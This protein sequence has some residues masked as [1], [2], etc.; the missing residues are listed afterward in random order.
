MRFWWRAIHGNL[1]LEELRKQEAEIFGDTSNKSSFRMKIINKNLD[2]NSF[3]PLPHK[4]SKFQI[5]GF[6]PDQTFEIEF[7]GKKLKSVKNAFI[8]ST[9][10]GGFGQRSRRGFGSIKVIEIDN[11]KLDFKYSKKEIEELIKN[12]NS[13]FSFDDSKF[14]SKREFP[15]IKSIEIGKSY[16]N[17]DDILKNIG[18]AT[19]K[20][21]CFGSANPRHASPIVVSVLKEKNNSYYPILTTLNGRGCWNNLQN[22]KGEI[23]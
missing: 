18:I 6:K 15:Y 2:A 11:D 19:H 1:S 8:L 22:F 4:S 16:C 17:Y 20:Y 7:L 5:K 21:S 12:L 14:K 9:I 3:N 23:L 13:E 10:L